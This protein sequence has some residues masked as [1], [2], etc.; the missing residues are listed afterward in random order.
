MDLPYNVKRHPCGFRGCHRRL[1][2]QKSVLLG[3]KNISKTRKERARKRRALK[4]DSVPFNLLFFN[5]LNQSKY[6]KNALWAN[7]L[8]SLD[9]MGGG[10]VKI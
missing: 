6:E 9:G 3:L 5:Y 2:L 7:L 8:M 10:R 1:S 4:N